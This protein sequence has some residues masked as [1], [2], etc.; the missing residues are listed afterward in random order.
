MILFAVLGVHP[1]L[2]FS[3]GG[4]EA[5]WDGWYE[6]R[7]RAADAAEVWRVKFPELQIVIVQADQKDAFLRTKT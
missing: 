2:P 4:H 3:A 6:D 1:T 7:K 5:Y